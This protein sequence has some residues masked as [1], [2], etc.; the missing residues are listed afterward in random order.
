[1][2]HETAKA[3][4]T[5]DDHTK[6]IYGVKCSYLYSDGITVTSPDDRRLLKRLYAIIGKITYYNILNNCFD[7]G[8]K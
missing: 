3:P 7:Y 8:I 2:V 1:M 5:N 6:E 4:L